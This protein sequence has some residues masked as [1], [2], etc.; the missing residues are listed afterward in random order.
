MIDAFAD[1]LKSIFGRLRDEQSKELSLL[2]QSYRA[3]LSRF[4]DLEDEI[5]ALPKDEATDNA[6]ASIKSMLAYTEKTFFE[7][8]KRT[9]LIDER[10][11]LYRKSAF[12]LAEANKFLEKVIF[13]KNNEIGVRKKEIEEASLIASNALCTSEFSFQI[14]LGKY[15]K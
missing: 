8:R 9:D 12:V 11:V 4:Y 2:I 6:V 15:I 7:T 13:F 5:E 14:L 3:E 10:Q 1:W